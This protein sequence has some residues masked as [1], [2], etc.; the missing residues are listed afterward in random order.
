MSND[1]AYPV[2]RTADR[3]LAL[4]AARRLVAFGARPWS[5]VSVET[6][7]PTAAEAIRLRDAL[8]E[9]WFTCWHLD[10]PIL[11][12]PG[13][14]DLTGG[15]PARE[16]PGDPV[17]LQPYLPLSLSMLDQPVGTVEDRFAKVVGGHM[18]A[19]R[20]SSLSWPAAPERDLYGEDKHA[21]VTLLLNCD[22]RE[23]DAPADTHLV[24][25]HVRRH[26]GDGYEDRFAQWLAERVGQRLIGPA[27]HA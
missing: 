16:L 25:V 12:A 1:V 6:E 2:F 13:V 8:P 4:R 19:I 24:L 10:A 27:Q 9:A 22:S 20:W 23:L 21:E 18:A 26:N 3:D 7:V 17:G 15:V 14:P 5:Q 11:A